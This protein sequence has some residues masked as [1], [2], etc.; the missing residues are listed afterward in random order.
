[1][2]ETAEDKRAWEARFGVPVGPFEGEAEKKGPEPRRANEKS[3]RRQQAFPNYCSGG[4]SSSS[5]STSESSISDMPDLRMPGAAPPYSIHTPASVPWRRSKHNMPVRGAKDTPK[6]FTGK[7]TDVQ[8]FVDHFE[9][10]IK[11]CRV[12][13]NHEKCELLLSYCSVDIQNIIRT[14]EGYEYRRWVVLK[15]ELLKYLT[16]IKYIRST[17]Q[18]M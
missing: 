13:S 12:A 17:N 4:S 2:F 3:R 5:S 8:L 9:H 6:T 11:K 15:P 16:R 14:L 1:M 18:L 7:Y 10:L